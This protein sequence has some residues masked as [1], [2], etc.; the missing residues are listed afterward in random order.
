MT[1]DKKQI[2]FV[3]KNIYL[4]KDTADKSGS[5]IGL[6]NLKKRLE[7]IYPNGYILVSEVVSGMYV[8]TLQINYKEQV[9]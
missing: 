1:M 3:T 7:L 8:S 6:M 4:P 9:S 5:G 2:L